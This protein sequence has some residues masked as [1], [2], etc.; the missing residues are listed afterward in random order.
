MIARGDLEA[1]WQANT[2]DNAGQLDV[3]GTTRDTVVDESLR[4]AVAA[5]LEAERRRPANKRLMARLAARCTKR[6][7]DTRPVAEEAGR[8][9]A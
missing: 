7:S 3:F 2:Y 9:R 1:E 6:I 8:K 4:D 5:V